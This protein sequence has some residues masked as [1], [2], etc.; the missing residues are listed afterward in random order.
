MS[1]RTGNKQKHETKNPI[2][3]ALIRRFYRKALD[4]VELVQPN[5]I[6]DLGCGEG[7]FLAELVAAGTSANLA[8]IDFSE[9]AL[10]EAKSKLGQRA[11]LECANLLDL[12]NRE[13]SYDLVTM[14]EV[15]EHIDEPEQILP[16]LQ[17]LS[18]GHI[19]L[20]VPREPWFC[21]LNFVRGKNLRRWGNDPEHVNH[22][23][24]RSFIRWLS[25][26]FEVLEAPGVFPWTMVLLRK[27][28]N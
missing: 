24:R 2:Q 4:M 21:I 5:S 15:M 19:L 13:D 25:P 28:S 9:D 3:R 7:Y 23:R 10:A 27:K 12:A 17:S 14:L 22:W 16:L 1:A 18:T 6:I 11:T 26:H 8:G 20:S